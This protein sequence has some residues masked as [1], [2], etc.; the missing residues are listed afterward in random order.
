MTDI[1]VIKLVNGTTLMAEM[2][3]DEVD[4]VSVRDVIGIKENLSLSP[5]G[6]YNVINIPYLYFCNGQS[7]LMNLEKR[8]ILSYDLAD[9]Y[10]VFYYESTAKMLLESELKK[11]DLILKMY[12]GTQE[13]EMEWDSLSPEE[14]ESQHLNDV[15][16]L[17]ETDDLDNEHCYIESEG[18]PTYH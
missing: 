15:D 1:I 10:S 4:Y 3:A 9:D 6:Y 14:K 5:A 16:D 2:I 8:Q 7:G 12:D 17:L 11:R 13:S 18:K